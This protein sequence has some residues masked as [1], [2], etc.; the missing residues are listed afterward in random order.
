MRVPF[1][2]SAVLLC[3]AC[4]TQPYQSTILTPTGQLLPQNPPESIQSPPESNCREFTTP[5]TVGGQPQ[6]AVG[7]ACEQP[8]GSW[9]ITQNTPG[10]APQVYTLP[11][12]AFDAYPYPYAYDWADPWDFGS[13]F[14]AGGSI[15]FGDG[16]R[17]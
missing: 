15:F 16:F 13:P 6:Q 5:V 9:Q 3:A 10:L 17:H 7:E 14:F 12:Q 11:P 1:S 4:A 2:L 8:D